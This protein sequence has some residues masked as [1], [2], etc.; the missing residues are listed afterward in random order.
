MHATSRTP[1]GGDS[2]STL[3]GSTRD[4]G[5]IP[6]NLAHT[7]GAT[8]PWSRYRRHPDYRCAP[9]TPTTRAPRP[10]PIRVPPR[11][12]PVRRPGRHWIPPQGPRTSDYAITVL[13]ADGGPVETLVGWSEASL[14][15][16]H[17]RT[18]AGIAGYRIVPCRRTGGR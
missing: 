5:D 15:E 18:L 17:A 7:G 9:C 13:D 12:L 4:G 2:S 14:A 6:P 1:D 3:P 16:E 8:G 11:S 10:S